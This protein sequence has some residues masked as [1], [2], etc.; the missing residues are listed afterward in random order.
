MHVCHSSLRNERAAES[1]SEIV[2]SLS[3]GLYE[4]KKLFSDT[5]QPK[6]HLTSFIY[7]DDFH[8]IYHNSR[9]YVIWNTA[10]MHSLWVQA[11]TQRICALADLITCW[12]YQNWCDF[13][14][15]PCYE[16]C[17]FCNLINLKQWKEFI[18]KVISLIFRQRTEFS[19]F[20]NMFFQHLSCL[21]LDLWL[22]H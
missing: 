21:G 8:M 18:T 3:G 2:M 6:L 15:E 10:N 4:T 12:P 19:M 1:A 14:I 9:C 11:M 16:C 17:D 5:K 22:L 7:A 20:L 13:V